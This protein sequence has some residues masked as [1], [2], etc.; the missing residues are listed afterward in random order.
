M[1]SYLGAILTVFFKQDNATPAQAPAQ[2]NILNI[3]FYTGIISQL[4]LP[5]QIC[6]HYRKDRQ[7]VTSSQYR[8]ELHLVLVLRSATKLIKPNNSKII[9]HMKKSHLRFVPNLHLKKGKLQRQWEKMGTKHWIPEEEG[10]WSLVFLKPATEPRRAIPQREDRSQ[11]PASFTTK[12][13]SMQTSKAHFCSR[14]LQ[15]HVAA[16]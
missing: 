14:L 9:A 5:Q 6:R 1:T 16:R 10:L 13:V 12:C 8:Q 4:Y 7:C 2:I 15:I 3:Y 11:N